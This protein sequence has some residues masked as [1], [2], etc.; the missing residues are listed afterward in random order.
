MFTY[1]LLKKLQESKGDVT[2]GEL[3][4]Y[5]KENVKRSS[6]RV[7]NKEQNPQVNPSPQLMAVWQTLKLR[8]KK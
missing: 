7:N 1:F 8:N 2:L 4:D 5:L 3:G 6:I